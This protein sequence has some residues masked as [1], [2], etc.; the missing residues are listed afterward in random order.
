MKTTASYIHLRDARFHAFHGV[1]PQER[2]VGGEFSVSLRAKVDTSA[3]VSHDIIDVTVNYA[4][5]YE[6]VL[7]E[8]MTPSFLLEHV[9]GRIGQAVFNSYPQVSELDITITK[10]NPPMGADCAGAAVELHL[11]NDKT[12][13]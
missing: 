6:I 4:D 8:M 12:D 10:L 7:H 9:A 11:I 2:Q 1:L 3:A 5:L 13:N